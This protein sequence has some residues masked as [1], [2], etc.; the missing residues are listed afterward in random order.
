MTQR[1]SV[2]VTKDYLVFCS[3]HFITYD[4]N[5]CE[6]LHG[7]NYRVA[8]ELTAGLDPN[9]YVFDFIALKNY[10]KEITDRLDHRMLVPGTSTRIRHTVEGEQVTLRFENRTWSFPREDC[11]I[12]PIA[13]TT[14]ELLAR[15]IVD[16]LLE[17][18]RRKHSFV[19]G[20][21]SVEVE[22]SF[23]QAATYTWT[24]G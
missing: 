21:L 5:T 11:V 14:A 4:G 8:C 2:R 7:H 22:E 15:H 1:Y 16:M 23:G 6:R 12:L 18:L 20:S 13:N 17:T 24:A 9:Q 19:P 3:G 10:L